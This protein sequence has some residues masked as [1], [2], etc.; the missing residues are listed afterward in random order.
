MTS[1]SRRKCVLSGP[2]NSSTDVSASSHSRVSSGSRSRV[3]SMVALN[4]VSPFA[5]AGPLLRI[6]IVSLS[7]AS[8]ASVQVV[9]FQEQRS[10]EQRTS[11]DP[12]H[13]PWLGFSRAD[14]GPGAVFLSVGATVAILSPN[15]EPRPLIP[16]Y[17]LPK[18]RT[19][20]ACAMDC[21]LWSSKSQLMGHAA[22]AA[23]F[24][25]ACAPPA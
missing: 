20:M 17:L 22:G 11:T 24:T 15:D 2:S 5:P 6:V 12:L 19:P 3:V 16:A 23:A 14:K 4:F 7:C 10:D 13:F 25:S 9:G 1:S 18:A 21:V 8:V